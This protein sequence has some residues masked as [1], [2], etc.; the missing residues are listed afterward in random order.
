MSQGG[1]SNSG[2]GS[3]KKPSMQPKKKTINVSYTENLINVLICTNIQCGN[4]NEVQ[5]M[6]QHTVQEAKVPEIA[7]K[8]MK[9]PLLTEM[10]E[11]TQGQMRLPD[12]VTEITLHQ[13]ELSILEN[14]IVHLSWKGDTPQVTELTMTKI[15]P[16]AVA[17]NLLKS[18]AG[19][20]S[21]FL[22][23]W[24]VLTNDPWVIQTLDSQPPQLSNPNYTLLT[25]QPRK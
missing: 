1:G 17:P 16:L 5:S 7:S 14:P 21:L 12:K 20:I 8:D 11:S 23:N 24:K 19:R 4:A 22:L 18:F 2:R 13:A 6:C 15:T 10:P 9:Q 25:P 3:F